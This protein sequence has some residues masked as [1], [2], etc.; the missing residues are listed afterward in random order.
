MAKKKLHTL[1]CSVLNLTFLLL[2]CLPCSSQ[3][4]N[5]IT[6]SSFHYSETTLRPYARRY[7]RV[8]LPLDFAFMSVNIKTDVNIDARIIGS[9]PKSKLP[10]ICFRNGSP[11]LPD[12]S[13]KSLTVLKPPSNDSI[14][15]IS[16]LQIME[17]CYSLQEDI[18]LLL[19]ND[20]IS[21]GVWYIGLF[22]GFGSA[23]T[24]SKM[25]IRGSDFWFSANVSVEGC[26]TSPMWG[27]SCNETVIPLSCSQSDVYTSSE[28]YFHGDLYNQ[29]AEIVTT[30]RSSF[31]VS[32]IM[33]KAPR[34]YSLD[35]TGTVQQLKVMA[36]NIS[37]NQ[38]SINS[39]G[40]V[41]G[42]LYARY[43][44]MPSGRFHDYHND[45]TQGPLIIASPKVG[46]WYISLL[47]DKQ[48]GQEDIC[49][50]LDWQVQGCP[51]GKAGRN[52]MWKTYILQTVIR[53]SSSVPFDSYYWPMGGEEISQ[54]LMN[55]HLEPLLSNTSLG[56]TS[57]YAW[58]YFL[59]DIPRGAAGGNIRVQLNS[60][61][62]LDYEIYSRYGGL[63]S[64]D[65]WD[66]YYASKTHISNESVSFMLDDSSDTTVSFY[67]LYAKEGTWSF[68]L[69]HPVHTGDS[70][71]YHTHMLIASERCPK[72]C[73]SHGTCQNVLDASGLTF[74]SYCFCD[75]D[76][77]GFDCSIEIVSHRGHI[78]QS[79]ALIASN[80]A[81]IFPAF[82][83]LRQKAFAE[84]VLFTTSGI[85]SGLYHACDVGTWCVLSFHILQ[86]MDF[87]LS[88]MAV[89]STFVYLP[90]IN[91][92]TKRVIHT[93]VA[94]LTALMAVRGATRSSNIILVIAIGALGLIIGWII[95]SST[96]IR[97]LTFPTTL[98]LDIHER[99][100]SLKSRFYNLLK[101]LR[102]RFRWW[103][104]FIGFV[105]LFLAG[106]SW[107]LETDESYWIWH[108]VWHVSIYTSSFFFLC[109][110]VNP[111][112][113]NTEGG[114]TVA[115][116][117]TRQD[118]SS[119]L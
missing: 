106:L 53:K 44:A 68:G 85:F 117:L 4:E 20:Q 3:N 98:N 48:T 90:N 74:Y 43:G 67:I 97:S 58:T 40:D 70:P 92:V 108:S 9:I 89:V 99:W 15:N 82:W 114:Q 39:T 83:T 36:V 5:P 17:Q 112:D 69:R 86:F 49:Y 94:I 87:W 41:R 118:S 104:V 109:S 52:C 38:K 28:N 59:L 103:F 6:V 10:L 62:K 65:T 107:K 115:Y 1:L 26:P 8:D 66:Y 51:L 47:P 60:D 95:E 116:E 88:F 71:E 27:Q 34:G 84:W 102:S 78:W 24:Q 113:S 119:R 32:C 22:N 64:L 12:V 56:N 31:D 45:I 77:G 23:S 50:S 100:Q 18:T 14:G 2:L 30:C 54:S 76:H 57:E 73:S 55:F 75:R 79:V 96:T 93:V 19:T 46:R 35:I 42:I 37:L 25:I 63:P 29:T 80:G 105:L 11:P 33:H 61:T 110:K 101:T 81:A 72:G 13:N 7:I 91:E 111:V 16:A 21:S